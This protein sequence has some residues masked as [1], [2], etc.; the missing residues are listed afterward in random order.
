MMAHYETVMP[1]R[2]HF[3]SYERLVEDTESEIRRLLSY[4]ELP[5]EENCLQFWRTGRAV[6]TPSGEQVRQ[7]IYRH[8]LE[9]WRNYE[10][11]LGPL[12]EALEQARAPRSASL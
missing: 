1:G 9:Q 8:A 6:A 4:C 10:P 7:P 3:L 2:V 5:F 11:W 12:K